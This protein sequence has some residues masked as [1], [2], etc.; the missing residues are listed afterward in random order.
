MDL[1][2]LLGAVALLLL[3]VFLSIG[4]DKRRV[5]EDFEQRDNIVHSVESELMEGLRHAWIV[6]YTD[7]AGVVRQA[8]AQCSRGTVTVL[9]D[10]PIEFCIAWRLGPNESRSRPGESPSVDLD[11]LQELADIPA[12]CKDSPAGRW[13]AALIRQMDDG[14]N[15]V[16]RLSEGEPL[17]KLDGVDTT[18]VS[19]A[20]ILQ[21][22]RLVAH[23]TMNRVDR[24]E[25]MTS[26]SPVD[27]AWRCEGDEP[28]RTLTIQCLARPAVPESTRT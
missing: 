14:E 11:V 5:V 12:H 10:D 27:L 21:Q 7:A 1:V 3:V 26:G 23:G 4:R 16:I 17:P 25:I 20:A 22:L 2:I 15:S 13:L 6:D 19:F 18:R 8:Q 28:H 24:I 9:K